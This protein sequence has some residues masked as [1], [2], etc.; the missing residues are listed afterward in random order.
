MT[1][2]PTARP[3]ELPP[4][5]DP[6]GPGRPDPSAPTHRRPRG[7]RVLA[8]VAGVLAAV[9][10]L[11]SVGGYVL[12]KLTEGRIHRVDVF[13]GLHD[14]PAKVSS[15]ENYLLVGSDTRE[16]LSA[17]ELHRLR[18]GGVESAA[19]RRSDTMILVHI[20]KNQSKATLISL[21]RDS[22]VDVPGHGF[23][24]MNAAYNLG[25]PRLTVQTVE[26]ATKVRIDHYVE[27]N[28]AGFTGMVDALG[29]VNICTPRAIHD[30][31]SHLT[32]S[33]GSHD[34]DGITALKYVR[35]RD[36]DG[37][38]DL[39]RMQRQQ[40]FIGA[41]MREA[42][43]SG[44][45]LNPIK[46]TKFVN[47]TIDSVR[48]DPGLS[49]GDILTLAKSLRHLDPSHV[50]FATVPIS[51]PDY[52]PGSGLGSTV[53]WDQTA[54]AQ[55][56]TAIR[57]DKPVGTAPGTAGGVAKVV[58]T[59]PPNQVRVRVLNGSGTQGLGSKAATD[60]GKAGFAVV[61][62]ARNSSTT[63]ATQ[64][65]I[66]YD[67]RWS[68]SVKTLQA[69]LPGAR[70]QP[71]AGLGGTFQVVV[72]SSYSGVTPVTVSSTPTTTATTAPLQTRTAAD[73]S[74]S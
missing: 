46:L 54:A 38:G 7:R 59:V 71:V 22:Y 33:A 18:V 65:V 3:G 39:G 40:G 20:S 52:R 28:F 61:G 1:T 37:R 64:T 53:Q 35:S 69:A 16:G 19:G 36:F 51:N 49:H 72:G 10:L 23:M 29:G 4:E 24:K 67:P 41:M 70:L 44:V 48:T 15:A 50:T 56:F 57:D 25:G 26:Q 58:A 63:G 73:A 43:S 55:L 6:R 12:L 17:S 47:A 74:C 27:I 68:R 11:V 13:G 42:I 14:R 2:T 8:W 34:L 60:L 21:P 45:L 9:V 32:L 5:L 66:R 62:S 30:P 31:K